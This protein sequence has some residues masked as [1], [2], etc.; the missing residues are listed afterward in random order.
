[1]IETH[2]V[3]VNVQDNYKNTPIHLALNWFNPLGGGDTTVLTYLLTQKSINANIKDKNGYTIIHMICAKVNNFPL[4]VFKFLI[5]TLGADVNVQDSDKNTPLHRALRSFS[6]NWGDISV[7]DYLLNQNDINVNIKGDYGF[8]LL[9]TACAKVNDLSLDVFKL[10][11]EKHGADVNAQAYNKDTPLHKAL[12]SFKPSGHR[13]MTVLTYLLN[14]NDINVNIKG[15]NGETLLHLACQQINDLSFDVFKLLIEIYGADVNTPNDNK[16][17]PLHLALSKFNLSGHRDINALTYL[18]NQKNININIKGKSG[19]TLL[20]V[21]CI[22]IN[23]LPIEIFKL[24]IETAG[25]DVNGQDN[26]KNTPIHYALCNFNP[27]WGGDITVLTY[28][29]SQK[30]VNGNIKGGDGATLL[31]TACAKVNNLPLDV[32]KL[33]IEAMGWDVN[34]PNDDKDTPLHNAFRCFDLH[35]SNDIS[36]LQYLLSQNNVDVNTKGKDGNTI[37]HHACEKIHDLPLNVFKILIATHGA[38]VNIQD[39]NNDTPLHCAFR[40]FKQD[41]GGNINVLTYLINQQNVN[42]N[43]K[44]KKGHTLL[45]LACIGNLSKSRRFVKLNAKADTILS[46]I[47][48]FIAE[49]C[50]QQ[51]LDETTP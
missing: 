31:H 25:C 23:T 29:L 24:L 32:F 12:Y 39:N 27:N 35:N 37:L 40:H 3:D 43:I 10:L 19:N 42:V 7:L 26:D 15:W 16:D 5:G 45:H 46:Q 1:L 14:Q 44:G 34:V 18:I 9:H 8:T 47:V 48:E 41:N 6:P 21:A 30:G 22:N 28:L 2:G 33:L 11:I 49:R 17:T 51:V 4:D 38:D 36:V 50:V 20:D 13:D